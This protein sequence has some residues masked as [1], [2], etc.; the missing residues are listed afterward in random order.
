MF[1]DDVCLCLYSD[2]FDAFFLV[3]FIYVCVVVVA[4]HEGC[5]DAVVDILC[6]RFVLV[7]NEFRG[8]K[9]FLV[10]EDFLGNHYVGE[11]LFL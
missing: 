11:S 10:F 3:Q 8:C 1:S 9:G 7:V 6:S 2:A 4:V 5:G